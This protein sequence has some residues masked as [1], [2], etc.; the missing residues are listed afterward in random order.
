M[1]LSVPCRTPKGRS[2]HTLDSHLGPTNPVG[3]LH[4]SG[5]TQTPPLLHGREQSLLQLMSFREKVQ[6]PSTHSIEDLTDT[7]ERFT[8]GPHTFWL[9]ASPKDENRGKFPNFFIIIFEGFFF[10]EKT[11]NLNSI[12][13]QDFILYFEW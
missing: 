12:V 2:G 1:S 4:R 6:R 7:F 11:R 8:R 3:H 10:L 9:M 5:P 13:E